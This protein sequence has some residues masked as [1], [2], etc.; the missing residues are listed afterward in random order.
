M[1]D[2]AGHEHH[3]LEVSDLCVTYGEVTALCEV[4]FSITCGHR[5]ALLG[6]NGA[7][8]STLI[9]TLAGLLKPAHGSILWRG[10]QLEGSTRE[11]AYLPQLDQHRQGFPLSVRDVVAMGRLPHLGV[12]RAFGKKDE[13]MVGEAIAT[14]RLEDLAERQID[15]LSGGQRQRAFIA[16]ALAQEAHIVMLDEPFNGLDVESSAELAETLRQLSQNGHLVV[17]SHHN[18]ATVED[19]YD[20]ALVLKQR[21]VAFGPVSEVLQDDEA[22]EALAMRKGAHV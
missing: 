9:R 8:K 19:C 14:M 3:R 22:R 15:A 7:G 20:D 21:Q 2:C 13:E 6:P 1:S 18:L 11:I 17:A 16:R 12:W 10:Q 5:L 4:N